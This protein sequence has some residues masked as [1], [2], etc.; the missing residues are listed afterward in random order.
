M[1]LY[2]SRYGNP[3]LRSG[4]YTAVRISL[5]IPKWNIGYKLNGELKDLMPFGLLNKFEEYEPFRDEY[6]KRLDRIGVERINL[7]L[8]AFLSY[9][10]DV[11]LLCYEDVRKGPSDWCHRTASSEWMKERTGLVIPELKDPTTPK[12][13][14]IAMPK[15]TEGIKQKP[16]F[17]LEPVLQLSLF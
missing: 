17:D 10:K 13:P 8:E 2:V 12:I 15:K 16:L 3:T 1:K 14:K 11:V 9:G 7:E 4:K 6:F 5:G